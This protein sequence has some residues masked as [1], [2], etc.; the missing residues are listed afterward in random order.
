MVIHRNKAFLKSIVPA[1]DFM[2][3]VPHDPIGKIFVFRAD[4]FPDVLFE[5]FVAILSVGGMV[6]V[7]HKHG[8]CPVFVPSG[9]D[10]L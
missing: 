10:F 5:R 4:I 6:F 1:D 3:F 7:Y 8:V 2:H 9:F